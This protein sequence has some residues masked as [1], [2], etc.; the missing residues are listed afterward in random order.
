MDNTG[1]VLNGSDSYVIH[2]PAGDIPPV[3]YFWSLTVYNIQTWLIANQYGKYSVGSNK[4]IKYNKDGSLDLYVQPTPPE[5]HQSNWLPSPPKT[6]F[7]LI[8]RMYGP[9]ATVVSGNYQYPTIRRVS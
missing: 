7:I 9:N 1:A 2:F 8:L 3:K 5:G 4:G 6:Q